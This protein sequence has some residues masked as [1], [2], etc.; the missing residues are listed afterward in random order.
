MITQELLKSILI[1][2]PSTGVFRWKKRD[3]R[4]FKSDSS[5]KSWNTKYSGSVAGAPFAENKRNKYIQIGVMGR[6]YLAHRLAWLYVHGAWPENDI[7]HINGDGRDNRIKNLRSVTRLENLR[8][9]RLRP[10]NKSGQTG[11]CWIKKSKKWK[12]AIKVSGKTIYLGLFNC[13]EDAVRVRLKAQ[14][15]YGFHENHGAK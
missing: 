7:D 2:N 8:N 10:N 14:K 11:V 15:E 4:F 12:A 3:R 5:F 13:Y 6:P 1:Y 9:Q